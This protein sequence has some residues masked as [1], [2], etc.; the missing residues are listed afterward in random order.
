MSTE[1]RAAKPL[2]NGEMVD[3]ASPHRETRQAGVTAK[4]ATKL[5][6]SACI[7]FGKN[8]LMVYNIRG[9]ISLALRM[10]RILRTG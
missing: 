9:G 3:A 1:Q 2:R 5:V 8:F 4:E 7:T 10:L 6:R